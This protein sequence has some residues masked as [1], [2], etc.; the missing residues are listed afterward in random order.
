MLDVD[1]GPGGCDGEG[2]WEVERR[3]VEVLLGR[4]EEKREWRGR[5][6]AGAGRG[7]EGREVVFW[8]GWDFRFRSS[9][10]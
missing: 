10:S 2:G 3:V 8:V 9:S 6:G 5:E 4:R 1:E 7:D